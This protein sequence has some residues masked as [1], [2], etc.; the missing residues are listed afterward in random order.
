M[1]G[2]LWSGNAS[3]TAEGK[4]IIFDP[5]CYY[6]D[7]EVDLAMSQ[8]F[9]GF[10]SAFYQGYQQIYPL[11]EGY[12]QRKTIYNLY[13]ILNHFNLFGGGFG[14]QSQSMINKIMTFN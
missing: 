10:P 13:H 11:N 8:L 1:H 12:E 14:S 6:G 9:G 5:A 7:R 4:P 3:F 2:D